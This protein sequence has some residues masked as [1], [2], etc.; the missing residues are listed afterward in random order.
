MK[1]LKFWIVLLMVLV[2]SVNAKAQESEDFGLEI[3]ET[4]IASASQ[5]DDEEF[6]EEE[7]FATPALKDENVTQDSETT[8]N[9]VEKSAE[10]IPEQPEL[11]AIPA[12]EN[13]SLLIKQLNLTDAQ[14]DAVKFLS[15][16]SRM[17]QEQLEKSVDLLKTQ[18]LEIE[19]QTMQE[20]REILTPEQQQ[21]FEN[22]LKLNSDS[23]TVE[24]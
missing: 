14:L 12:E 5:T 3:E 23:A 18:A 15:D 8:Q 20:F 7:I 10:K 24:K 6:A 11:D 22:I 1:L 21:I 9:N 16:E 2:L 13:L 4:S 17:R 19:T